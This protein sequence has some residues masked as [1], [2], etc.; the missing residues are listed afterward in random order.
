M[1][2]RMTEASVIIKKGVGGTRGILIKGE[3]GGE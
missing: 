2:F 3:W 1:C